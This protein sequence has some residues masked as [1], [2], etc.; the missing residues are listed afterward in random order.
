MLIIANSMIMIV[1]LQLLEDER[2]SRSQNLYYVTQHSKPNQCTHH[3]QANLGHVFQEVT[4]DANPKEV[5]FRPALPK[6]KQIYYY[7]DG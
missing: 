6:R 5:L 7:D 1:K 2:V 4:H 3:F